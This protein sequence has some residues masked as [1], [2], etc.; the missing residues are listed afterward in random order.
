MRPSRADQHAAR[1]AHGALGEQATARILDQLEAEGWWVRHDLRLRGRRFNL[2]HVLVSP[3][4]T[5]LVVVDSK[6]WRRGPGHETALVQGRVHC[7]RDDRHAQVQALA[8]YANLVAQ[9]VGLPAAAVR[10]LLV[11]HGSPVA[12]G[13]FETA[14]RNE[15]V[16]VLGPDRLLT[17]LRSAPAGRDA[18]AAAALA[19]RVDRVLVPYGG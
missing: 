4:G 3:C 17:T 18:R 11:V 8:G 10:P 9:A 5:G 19:V 13:W 15:R 7:G 6:H 14:V 2:D 12:G 1:L 16:L